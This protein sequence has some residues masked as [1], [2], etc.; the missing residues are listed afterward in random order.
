MKRGSGIKGRDD[1]SSGLV[2]LMSESTPHKDYHQI[3][4]VYYFKI[5]NQRSA[6]FLKT[7]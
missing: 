4:V 6:F 2:I 3:V 1:K 5:D 7:F